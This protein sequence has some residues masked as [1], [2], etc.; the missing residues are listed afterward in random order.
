MVYLTGGLLQPRTRAFLEIEEL[1][2]WF[3]Q[4]EPEP[5]G[6]VEFDVYEPY[7]PE[8]HNE[9]E[10]WDDWNETDPI[11][12]HNYSDEYDPIDDFEDWNDSEFDHDDN[13]SDIPDNIT[14][15]DNFPLVI[16]SEILDKDGILTVTA[17][18]AEDEDIFLIVESGF[19]PPS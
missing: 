12:D 10:H 16:I 7:L 5:V 18:L 13:F 11:F 8:D 15:E 2:S 14:E 1:A 9:S 3:D 17:Q 4:L 19:L 6:F